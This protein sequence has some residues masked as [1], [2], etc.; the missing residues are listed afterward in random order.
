MNRELTWKC[1]NQKAL[2]SSWRAGGRRTSGHGSGEKMTVIRKF[3]ERAG[4]E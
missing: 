4:E 1:F 2:V 3:S